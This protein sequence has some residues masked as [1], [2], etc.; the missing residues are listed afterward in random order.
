MDD[1][2][3]DRAILPSRRRVTSAHVR[4]DQF[5]NVITLRSI[6]EEIDQRV[7]NGEDVFSA[8]T[9]V[10]RAVHAWQH[11]DEATKNYEEKR[12]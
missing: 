7:R 4:L 3:L 1:T 11:N 6:A 9:F 10:T 12:G 5:P 8:W 2:I